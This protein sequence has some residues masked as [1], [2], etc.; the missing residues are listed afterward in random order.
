M[1]SGTKS[2]IERANGIAFC[3]GLLL[4]I[5]FK[6]VLLNPKK[7]TCLQQQPHI[8]KPIIFLEKP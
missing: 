1:E 2:N 5:N 8:E 3:E 4:E 6:S 7:I